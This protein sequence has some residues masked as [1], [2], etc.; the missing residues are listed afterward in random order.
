MEFIKEVEMGDILVPY[1]SMNNEVF[2][3]VSLGYGEACDLVAR[4]KDKKVHCIEM[5]LRLNL[6]VLCQVM[7][8]YKKADFV[9]IAV[10]YGEKKKANR[11]WQLFN[12]LSIGVILVS[13]DTSHNVYIERNARKLNNKPFNWN[14]YLSKNHANDVKAGSKSGKRSTPFSRTV[15]R[16]KCYKKNNPDA[17]IEDCL[18]NIKHHYANITS[19]R[20]SIKKLMKNKIINIKGF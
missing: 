14:E 3:E 7:H 6:E 1:L 5:K 15:S 20:N 2:Q 19:A 9:W 4:D 17:T 16:I 18:K 13:K 11:L 10:P 12:T 8:W